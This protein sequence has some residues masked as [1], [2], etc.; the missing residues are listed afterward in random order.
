[1]PFYSNKT[2]QFL[3]TKEKKRP[4]GK[5]LHQHMMNIIQDNKNPNPVNP[6]PTHE[7]GYANAYSKPKL[8]N[9]N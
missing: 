5:T 8:N 2:T 9:I 4:K 6:F 1:M 3:I 7:T